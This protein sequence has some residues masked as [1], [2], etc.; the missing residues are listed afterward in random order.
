MA[1]SKGDAEGLLKASAV[2]T[3]NGLGPL[4]MIAMGNYGTATRIAAGKYGSC[5]TF[6]AG[7]RASAPGQ[8]DTFTMK[9]WLDDYYGV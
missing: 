2:L 8:A 1:N 7:S 3:R 9:K 4:V 6:A 5:M